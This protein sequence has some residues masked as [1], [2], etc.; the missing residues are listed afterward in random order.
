MECSAFVSLIIL[1]VNLAVKTLAYLIN[2]RLKKET[3][4]KI[5]NFGEEYH[6]TI[7]STI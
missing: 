4:Q 1:T 5:T 7:E 2:K 3:A 6:E